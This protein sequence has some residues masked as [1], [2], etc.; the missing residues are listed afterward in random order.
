M[1]RFADFDAHADATRVAGARA[2][3][4]RSLATW[5]YL[6]LVPGMCFV[7]QR[8]GFIS[9]W[10]AAAAAGAALAGGESAG[11]VGLAGV[12]PLGS[13]MMLPDLTTPATATVLPSNDALYGASHVELDLLGPMVVSVPANPTGRYYS[14][15]V[16]DAML[17][18]V[19]RVGP[20]W[21]G[22]Q[23]GDHLIVPP[24]WQGDVPAGMGC[25][26]APTASICLFA[27]ALVGYEP[28]GIDLVRDWMRQIRLTPLAAWGRPDPVCPDVDTT[29]FEFA[30]I[31]GLT[32][33][34]E[35]LR[36]GFAHLAHN[37]PSQADTWL[38]DLFRSGDFD[39]AQ[40]QPELREAVAAGVAEAQA[41][42]DTELTTW[43][44]R[45]GWMLPQ[46]Y[47]GLPGPH[48]A[49]AAAFQLFQVGS[50]EIAESAYYFNDTDADGALLDGSDDRVYELRFAADELPEI[51]PGGYWSLTM[52]DAA[53]NLLVTNPINRYSTRPTR[54]GMVT[55]P[56]GGLTITMAATLPSGVPEANWLP[57]PDGQFRLGLRVYYPGAAIQ[58]GSWTPPSVK[59]PRHTGQP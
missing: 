17:N 45:N 52:Y 11:A 49:Q 20:K 16:M 40:N 19:G 54:P 29:A 31:G 42:V 51:T 5:A 9:G 3:Q 8:A 55:D 37:P 46:P 50:N 22:N 44:R 34:F 25:I 18:N 7:R 56:D 12:P 59:S 23:A 43:P 39:H 10:R 36:I 53:T 24:G 58:G 48:V 47:L 41:I 26:Q 32:D 1:R 6:Y 14:V 13:W 38:L 57:A 35:Y 4:V 15:S 28:G 27:R 2:A 33:P 21:T 30:D